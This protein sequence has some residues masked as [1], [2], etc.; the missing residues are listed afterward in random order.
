MN[1]DFVTQLK[2][3]LMWQFLREKVDYG[4][5]FAERGFQTVMLDNVSLLATKMGLNV[6]LAEAL[7]ICRAGFFVGFGN[8]GFDVFYQIFKENGFDTPVEDLAFNFIVYDM[9]QSFMTCPEEFKPYLK[10]LFSSTPLECDIE[11]VK[12]VTMCY[13]AMNK[14]KFAKNISHQEFLNVEKKIFKL[15]ETEFLKENKVIDLNYDNLLPQGINLNKIM[16]DEHK[17]MLVENIVTSLED[18]NKKNEI[19]NKILYNFFL[20][21]IEVGYYDVILK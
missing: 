15:F 8:Q 4:L 19:T 17:K 1:R 18:F 10:H 21:I 13:N 7:A 11:E 5:N 20:E 3:S 14:I 2:R 12:L 9:Y 6:Y 16:T